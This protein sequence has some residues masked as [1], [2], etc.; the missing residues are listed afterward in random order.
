MPRESAGSRASADPELRRTN[1]SNNPEEG[2][3]SFRQKAEQ[4]LNLHFDPHRG[5]IDA[6]FRGA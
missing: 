2:R 4:S 1:P 5:V 6:D 3:I